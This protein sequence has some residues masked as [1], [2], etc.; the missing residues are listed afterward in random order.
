VI[1]GRETEVEKKWTFFEMGEFEYL[2]FGEF[3]GF[4]RELGCGFRRLGLRAGDRV[5][6]FAETWSVPLHFRL[7][8]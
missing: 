1:D 6:V 8:S 2:T 5:H 3:E 7:S 4:V